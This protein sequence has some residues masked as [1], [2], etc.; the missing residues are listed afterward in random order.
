MRVTPDLSTL[1][2][3]DAKSLDDIVARGHNFQ[4]ETCG[5]P[6]KTN[7]AVS[8][9]FST[10]LCCSPCIIWS[11]V[12][13]IVCCP[14]SCFIGNGPCSDNGCTALSD[15]AIKAVHDVHFERIRFRRCISMD[16][17]RQRALLVYAARL[18]D[19]KLKENHIASTTT[20]YC[21]VDCIRDL[22]PSSVP[23]TPE[24]V[25]KY[26]DDTFAS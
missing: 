23:L 11:V 3:R 26:V 24:G 16:S 2:E 25:L 10:L 4:K 8:C 1:T 5:G 21:I 14:A 6:Y 18:I 22:I 7:R 20:A 19:N 17:A 15:R 9:V 13:R 12:M